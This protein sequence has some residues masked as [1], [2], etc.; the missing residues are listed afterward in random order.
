MK[1]LLPVFL[2]SFALLFLFS[3]VTI[4]ADEAA[5][6]CIDQVAGGGTPANFISNGSGLVPCGQ[7]TG[8]NGSLTCPCQ[9]GHFFIMIARI[10]R[11]AI[12]FIA[13]PLAG[14]LVVIGGLLILLSGINQSWYNTGKT[15]LINTGIAL[16]II[17]CAYIIVDVVLHAL[18]YVIAWNVF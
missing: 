3:G 15:I 6:I 4:A 9:L 11:F 10:F 8:T 2:A 18:G 12:Y 7:T 14:L 13:L 5:A 1:K 16:A 17:F